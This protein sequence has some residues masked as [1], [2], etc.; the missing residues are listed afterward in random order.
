MSSTPHC[1]R[2]PRAQLARSSLILRVASTLVWRAGGW[3]VEIRTGGNFPHAHSSFSRKRFSWN[4]FLGV[5][6][7]LLPRSREA[8]TRQAGRSQLIQLQNP[9]YPPPVEAQLP[10]LKLPS[11]PTLV[12]HNIVLFVSLFEVKLQFFPRYFS[13][14][15]CISFFRLLTVESLKV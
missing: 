2:K 3:G 8:L 9:H 4:T 1:Q 13:P 15:S 11:C 7:I 10:R 12:N 14:F 5:S 6:L